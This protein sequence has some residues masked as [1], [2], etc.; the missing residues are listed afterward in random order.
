MS[1][2]TYNKQEEAFEL[3]YK[4]WGEMKTVRFYVEE[5]AEIMEHLSSV[6]EKLAKLDAG[7]GQIAELL[8][9]EGYY[10]GGD[11]EALAKKL[12]LTNPYVD[13]DEDD[14][15]LC[16]DVSTGDGY[17]MSPAHGELFGELFEITGWVE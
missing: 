14:V 5:E 8:I 3:P 2:I 15:T 7:R 12:I 1:N 13:F 11:S 4:L 17:M 10:E 6:A 16:F 9:D